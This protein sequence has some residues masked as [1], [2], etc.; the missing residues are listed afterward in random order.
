MGAAA[1]ACH[2]PGTWLKGSTVLSHFG[3]W[4]T[5]PRPAAT[6]GVEDVEPVCHCGAGKHLGVS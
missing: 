1:P 5:T 4:R 2:I 3:R 6:L